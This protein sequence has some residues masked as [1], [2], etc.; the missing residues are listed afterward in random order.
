MWTY[1]APLADMRF[2]IEDVLQANASWAEVPTFA[3]LD[4]DTAA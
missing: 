4:I 1:R 3:D 2:V